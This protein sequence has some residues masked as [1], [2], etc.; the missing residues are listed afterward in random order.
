MMTEMNCGRH[1]AACQQLEGCALC[2]GEEFC[3]VVDAANCAAVEAIPFFCE[4]FASQKKSAKFLTRILL[5]SFFAKHLLRRNLLRRMAWR[6]RRQKKMRIGNQIVA[7][8]LPKIIKTTYMYYCATIFKKNL[9][10]G[11][12]TGHTPTIAI[13]P[14]CKRKYCPFVLRCIPIFEIENIN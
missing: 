8:M 12:H 14:T 3:E 9:A 10:F 11:G 6:R 5:R 13:C 4:A 2:G 1:G 7:E